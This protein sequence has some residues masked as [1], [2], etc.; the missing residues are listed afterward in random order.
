MNYQRTATTGSLN[1][2]V[3]TESS[4]LSNWQEVS[5]SDNT[6]WKVG[7][8]VLSAK[9]TD[10]KLNQPITCRW[11]KACFSYKTVVCKLNLISL[12]QHR[13][14]FCLLRGTDILMTPAIFWDG[15][16]AIYFSII[17][18][19]SS[20]ISQEKR[21]NVPELK[22]ETLKASITVLVG[23]GVSDHRNELNRQSFPTTLRGSECYCCLVIHSCPTLCDPMDCSPPGP[24]VHWNSP[25]KNT[26]VGCHA[27]L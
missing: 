11:L 25:G 23:A 3:V 24:S 22:N 9:E 26:G 5:L 8:T 12:H 18:F 2:T 1:W 4:P 6:L 19:L 7:C 17:S 15:A 10:G 14:D 13:M 16:S 20:Q 21:V 27:L